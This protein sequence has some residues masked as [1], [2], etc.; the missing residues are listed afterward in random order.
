MGSICVL[1]GTTEPLIKYNIKKRQFPDKN[2]K[3]ND[4]D[5]LYIP[6][7]TGHSDEYIPYPTDHSEKSSIILF[8]ET[9]FLTSVVVQWLC[10]LT[11]KG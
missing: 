5:K 1:R 10:L 8:H 7:P 11:L 4:N 3:K 9:C 2:A 6:Y